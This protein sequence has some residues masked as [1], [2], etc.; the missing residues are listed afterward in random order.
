MISMQLPGLGR[1]LRIAGVA[2]ARA[3]LLLAL[4]AAQAQQSAP[5]S[6]ASVFDSQIYGDLFTTPE[7]QLVFSD[8]RLISYWLKFEVELAGVQASLGVIP[9]AAAQAI[10][11][12]AR[13]DNIDIAKLRAGTNIVGRAIEPLLLQIT[14]AGDPSVR[15]FLHWGGTTQ[16]VMDTA[17]VLQM[18]DGLAII[19]RDLRKLVL[20]L[21]DKASQYRDTPMVARSNGQDA[22]PTTFGMLL[23]S[24]MV[25]LRRHIDRLDAAT[26]RVLV[27]QYGSAVGTLSSAGPDGLKIRAALM[28]KLGLREPDLSWNASRDNYAEVIQTLA[29]VHGTMNRIAI[30]IN[31]WS[32]TA[33]NGVN[34][35]EGGV[36]STMPQKRNPRAS[37]FMGGIA[38]LAKMRAA[39]ALSM[40]DQSETRQGAPWISE[41]S[42][43]P[44]MFML[45]AA[46]LDR[47]N[48]LFANLIVRPEV[49]LERFNDSR[50]FV[51]AEAVMMDIAPKIGREPAYDLIK[52]AIRGSP[53]G[54]SFKDVIKKSPRLLDLVGAANIDGVLDP[55]NY[56]G[57]APAMVDAAI[58]KARAGLN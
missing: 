40:L 54:T 15:Q 35:G 57:A 14:A 12:A 9:A 25:E 13:P 49:M 53:P 21:A 39:G 48:A 46:T 8:A 50:G 33:D 44:E 29:L 2:V 18:R 19:R 11:G 3:A 28:Q 51:M 32:R 1:H 58:A 7:M 5:H 52:E 56:L 23:A 24:Y 27:G 34:E 36:S 26:A 30:D 31:L 55:H 42:T 38:Y 41:W 6:N 17:T 20:V 16:D 37:E 43:I 10:A 47:A 4:P 45:T 22:I